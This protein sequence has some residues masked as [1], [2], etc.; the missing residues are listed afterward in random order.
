M[1]V[2]DV[3]R[4]HAL[5]VVRLL[6]PEDAGAASTA[7]RPWGVTAGGQEEGAGEA[8][9]MAKVA[10]GAFNLCHDPDAEPPTYRY[11]CVCDR[12]TPASRRGSACLCVWVGGTAAFKPA[13]T[14]RC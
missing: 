3:A 5:A 7:A 11:V 1:W 8:P 2:K 13:T 4:A 9:P 10:G 14:R 12:S 6:F